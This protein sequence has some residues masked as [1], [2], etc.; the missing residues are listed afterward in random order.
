MILILVP[1][2]IQQWLISASN[3]YRVVNSFGLDHPSLTGRRDKYSEYIV[4]YILIKRKRVI[5]LVLPNKIV[6][7]TLQF[8]EKYEIA[9]RY[10]CENFVVT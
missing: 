2:G 10:F 7:I 9:D 1:N 3:L 8:A 5:F 6:E 4:F